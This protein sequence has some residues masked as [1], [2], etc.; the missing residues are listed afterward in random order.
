ML[1]EQPTPKLLRKCITPSRTCAGTPST[2]PKMLV[3]IKA[4]ESAETLTNS[5]ATCWIDGQ[6]TCR[7]RREAASSS[8]PPRASA[9]YSCD[10]T[11]RR[12]APAR[13]SG[14]RRRGTLASMRRKQMRRRIQGPG[15]NS[16]PLLGCCCLRLTS[17]K[18]EIQVLLF[19][20]FGVC[21]SARNIGRLQ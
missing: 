13:R 3:S 1:F 6:W 2:R 10:E 19:S 18:D 14:S 16:C 17:D 11:L 21:F 8:V 15:V 5:P 4:S 7:W 12:R 9:S 20:T